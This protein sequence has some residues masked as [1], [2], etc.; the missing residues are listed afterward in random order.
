MGAEW[1]VEAGRD[2][3]DHA[4]GTSFAVWGVGAQ[5]IVGRC[6]ENLGKAGKDLDPLLR[7]HCFPLNYL[8]VRLPSET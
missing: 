6:K 7:F 5:S 3:G 2:V 8:S 4:V 1:T